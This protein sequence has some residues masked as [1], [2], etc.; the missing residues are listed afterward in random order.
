MSTIVKGLLIFLI[1]LPALAQDLAWPRMMHTSENINKT[2]FRGIKT[3]FDRLENSKVTHWINENQLV[4]FEGSDIVFNVKMIQRPSSQDECD[5]Y[6]VNFI[7]AGGQTRRVRVN[8]CPVQESSLTLRSFLSGS[9]LRGAENYQV[10][11]YGWNFSITGRAT[12]K[13]KQTVYE[14]NRGGTR[15]ILNETQSSRR[16]YSELYYRCEGC[17][18][19]A[20]VA[21]L[22]RTSNGSIIERFFM[23]LEGRPVDAREFYQNAGGYLGYPLSFMPIMLDD[24][25]YTAGWPMLN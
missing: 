10:V 8:T 11:F 17:T 7:G 16:L 23:G 19:D 5:S 21:A 14:A 18:G 13:G 9:F 6:M 4:V 1:A 20:V 3:Y 12:A 24:A 22:E 2:I 15:I 25:Q